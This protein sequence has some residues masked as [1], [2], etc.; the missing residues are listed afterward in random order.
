MGPLISRY[1]HLTA[2]EAVSIVEK[3]FDKT[4]HLQDEG[5]ATEADYE[6]VKQFEH[7]TGTHLHVM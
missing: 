3:N 5:N 1:R 4:L 7:R 2:P 6:L